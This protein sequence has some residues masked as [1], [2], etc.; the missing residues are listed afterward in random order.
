VAAMNGQI[1][2]PVSRIRYAFEPRGESLVVYS[3]LEPGGALPPHLHPRQ[4]ERWSVLEGEVR[5]RLGREKRVIG[6]P[7]G[8]LVVAPGVAHGLWSIGDAEARLQAVVTP[9]LRLQAFLEES[10]AAGRDGL[11]TRRGLPRGL[12]GA[13]WAASFVKRYRDETV[14]LSP[15][16]IVLRVLVATLARDP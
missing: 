12:R 9:P 1:R 14:F 16:P 5:F 13:R 10:A 7:D 15:P 4:E 8:E 3:W 11:F 6:P 2:D